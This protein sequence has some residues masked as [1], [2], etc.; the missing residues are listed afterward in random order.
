MAASRWA[1]ART[2]RVRGI[3]YNPERQIA[4]TRGEADAMVDNL[5]ISISQYRD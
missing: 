1:S 5:N 4:I 3:R 2:S